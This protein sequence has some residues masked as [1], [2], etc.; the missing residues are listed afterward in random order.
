MHGSPEIKYAFI[1]K[2]RDA[3]PVA[4]I[5]EVINVSK[6]GY[7]AWKD[8]LD[9]ARKIKRKELETAILK[10]FEDS[11]GLYGSPRVFAKL[12]EM[13]YETSEYTVARIMKSLGLKVK[14]KKGFKVKTTD[15]NHNYDISESVLNQTFEVNNPGEILLSDITYIHT[16]E[17]WLYL[18]GVMDL[19]TREI[20]G[21][22]MSDKIDRNITISALRMAVKNSKLA[23]DAI[24]H[25]DRGVQYACYAFKAELDHFGLKQSMSRTGNCYDNAPMESFFIH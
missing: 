19:S 25:S 6:S 1:D 13:D 10:I 2:H 16:D 4:L 21:W 15:S 20:V 14:T 24:F 18:A 17:G 11:R 5:C 12:K 8:R 7:Y 3:Y 22:K 9:L 23:E